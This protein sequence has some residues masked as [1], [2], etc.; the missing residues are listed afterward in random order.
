MQSARVLFIIPKVSD[1]ISMTAVSP[2][3][4]MGCTA[5]N[6]NVKAMSRVKLIAAP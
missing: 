1:I 5:I 2:S 4:D 6:R 3:F